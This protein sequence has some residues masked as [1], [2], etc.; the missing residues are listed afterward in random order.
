[1]ILNAKKENEN[2]TKPL[3]MQ[4]LVEDEPKSSEMKLRNLQRDIEARDKIVRDLEKDLREEK[5][6]VCIFLP[7]LSN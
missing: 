7:G 5:K 4:S 3:H 1:M 2:G 6:T